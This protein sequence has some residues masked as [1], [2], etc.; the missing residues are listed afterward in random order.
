[1]KNLVIDLDGTLTIDDKNLP[2]EKKK[3]NEKVREKLEIYKKM[4]FKITIFTS[5]NMKTFKG[6]LSKIKVYTLPKI[7]IWLEKNHITYDELIVG[8]P[9]CGEEG[10]YIDDKAVRPLEFA[11]LSP[12]ELAKL[13][14]NKRKQKAVLITSAK[15]SSD[16]FTLEFGKIVP[17]FLPLGNK[18]LYEYQANL[19]KD[20]KIF[21]SLP[22]NF[23]INP[24]DLK[25][26]KNLGIKPLFV[27]NELNLGQSLVYCMNLLCEKELSIIHGDCFFKNLELTS[28]SLV[29]AK[30]KENYNWAYLDK[31]FKTKNFKKEEQNLILAGAFH[32]QNT[33]TLIKTI[34]Q[35]EYSFIKGLKAYSKIL[36]F[37]VLE[38][39]TWLDFGLLTSY[40]H[41]KKVIQTQRAF[42]TLSHD[43]RGGGLH[44]KEFFVA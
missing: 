26:L 7:K 21:L 5:R 3:V 12:K 18:R 24:F 28:N 22:K 27:P 17:S 32:I 6:D 11:E 25:K 31:H 39:D 16:E 23:N 33:H 36:P 2:Y 29:V 34:I 43:K 15:Y 41:S 10:F 40:F 42:N 38:N 20:Y 30:V 4:G 37:E 19:F 1:M 13:V 35:N 9:W 14:S 8:K 44:T